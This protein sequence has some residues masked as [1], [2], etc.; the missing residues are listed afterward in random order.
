M[1]TNAKRADARAATRL[2]ERAVTKAVAMVKA[3]ED[4][5]QMLGEAV[6]S[7]DVLLDGAA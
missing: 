1:T 3:G 4:P 7:A 6:G 2:L 5:R